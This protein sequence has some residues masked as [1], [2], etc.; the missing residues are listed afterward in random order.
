MVDDNFKEVRIFTQSTQS[1]S[2]QKR[3]DFN[4]CIICEKLSELCVK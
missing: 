2:M 4:L 3:K 1:K